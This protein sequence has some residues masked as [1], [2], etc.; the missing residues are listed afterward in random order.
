MTEVPWDGWV[1]GHLA[2]E[3]GV[4]RSPSSK[5]PTL[6]TP[7]SSYGSSCLSGSS[8]GSW[9]LLYGGSCSGLVLSLG[10]LS[11]RSLP[12]MA[13]C[14]SCSSA[15]HRSSDIRSCNLLQHDGHRGYGLWNHMKYALKSV[16]MVTF[17]PF[18]TP[19]WVALPTLETL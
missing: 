18:L 12:L 4:V 7:F 19:L 16:F 14:G 5:L 9:S 6:P 10:L 3:R 15:S 8:L 11:C 13:S 1:V 2:E 17:C